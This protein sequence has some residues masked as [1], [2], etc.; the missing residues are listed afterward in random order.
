MV[1]RF[2][3][4]C[5]CL[6]CHY[7]P[8]T[9]ELCTR[10]GSPHNDLHSLLYI[11]AGHPQQTLFWWKVATARPFTLNRHIVTDI[12]P[13]TPPE[14]SW[15]TLCIPFHQWA[16]VSQ[17]GKM[18]HSYMNKGW[19]G[20][21]CLEEESGAVYWAS[22]HF[23]PSR[24]HTFWGENI[25]L[26]RNHTILHD[27]FRSPCGKSDMHNCCI[28]RIYREGSREPAIPTYSLSLL[29]IQFCYEYS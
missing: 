26:S 5:H 12:M 22:W 15:C 13:A 21:G 7:S 28:R 1:K 29:C 16:V 17:V 2:I 8:L 27:T 14:P 6:R 19:N 10:S 11:V 23:C 25:F 24:W 20:L 4:R 9:V 18:T 3:C